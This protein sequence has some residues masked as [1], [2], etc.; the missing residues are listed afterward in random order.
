M[1]DLY[2][3]DTQ[4]AQ[5]PH[6]AGGSRPAYRVH[7]V[8]IGASEQFRPEYLKINPNSKIPAIVDQDGPDGGPVTLRIRRDPDLSGGEDRQ[9]PARADGRC[10]ARCNG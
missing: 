7:T 4:R 10:H 9:V 3:W 6:H 8:N 2:T 1:I 5:D